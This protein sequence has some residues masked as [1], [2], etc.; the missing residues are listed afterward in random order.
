LAANAD[1]NPWVH[2]ETKSQNYAP[3]PL[4]T[5]VV[6]EMEVKDLFEKKGHEFVDVLVNIFDFE[7]NRCYSSIELRAIYKLRG[8]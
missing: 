6:G 5:K 3:I 7:S 8:L 2:M 1:M 4:G